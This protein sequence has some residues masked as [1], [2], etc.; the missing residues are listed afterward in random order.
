MHLAQE[1][2]VGTVN[3]S[4]NEAYTNSCLDFLCKVFGIIHNLQKTGFRNLYMGESCGRFR[5]IISLSK[6]L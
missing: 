2:H 6:N 3:V 5:T 4:S 1:L